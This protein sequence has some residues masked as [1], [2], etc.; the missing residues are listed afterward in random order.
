MEGLGC[1][2]PPEFIIFWLQFSACLQ[3][4]TAAE[5]S[6]LRRFLLLPSLHPTLLPKQPSSR[7][8][9]SGHALLRQTLRR[10]KCGAFFHRRAGGRLQRYKQGGLA[11]AKVFSKKDGLAWVDSAGRNWTVTDLRDWM[12]ARAQAGRL[13]PKGFPKNNTFGRRF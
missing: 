11:D 4:L 1:G 9:A 10:C 5:P 13:P 2:F 12:G 3:K 7:R 8:S 6:K